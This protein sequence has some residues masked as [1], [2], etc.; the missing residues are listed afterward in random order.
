M[1][2]ESAITFAYRIDDYAVVQLLTNVNLTVGETVAITGVGNGFDAA[3]ALVTALPQYKFTHVDNDGVLQYD[4]NYPIPNQ[5]LY[6]NVG[7]DVDYGPVNPY[8]SLTYAFTC[9]WISV[10]DLQNYLGLVVATSAETTFLAQCRASGNAFCFRRRREA[11][12]SDQLGTPPDESVK[13]GTLMYAA[14]MYRQRGSIDTFA[15]FDGMSTATV[16]GLSA[17]IKQLLGVDRPQV[18]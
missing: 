15:G 14:S 5:V 2:E 8:G 4:T 18:A 11:G 9:T 10:A 3:T 7:A 17:I 6:Q 12:Y 16:S 1:A 13:L